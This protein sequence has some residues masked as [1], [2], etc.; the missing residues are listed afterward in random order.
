MEKVIFIWLGI[1]TILYVVLIEFQISD[2]KQINELEERKQDRFD[3]IA[4]EADDKTNNPT[5]STE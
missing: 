3:F 1:L 2:Q 5:D 4:K